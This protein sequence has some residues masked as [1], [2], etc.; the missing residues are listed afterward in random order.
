MV[1][2]KWYKSGDG[3]RLYAIEFDLEGMFWQVRK[4]GIDGARLTLRR[5]DMQYP[6]LAE[7]EDACDR[8]E[9]GLCVGQ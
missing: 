6:S 3:S 1:T 4:V 9:K 8:M 5:V 7:A 2:Q